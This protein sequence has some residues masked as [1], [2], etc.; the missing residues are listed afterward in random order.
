[1]NFILKYCLVFISWILIIIQS[2][3]IQNFSLFNFF[4]NN[5]IIESII[6]TF[7][8]SCLINSRS[9]RLLFINF[10]EAA[11]LILLGVVGGCNILLGW[12]SSLNPPLY[13][14]LNEPYYFI[15]GF[16]EVDSYCE[17]HQDKQ[18][19]TDFVSQKI[20]SIEISED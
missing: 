17:Y 15:K 13:F 6:M 9:S 5:V 3:L 7:I 1:M 20:F 8:I 4:S 12:V 16:D 10:L 2:I 18:A 14:Q 11:I 19:E